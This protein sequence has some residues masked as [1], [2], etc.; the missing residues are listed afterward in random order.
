MKLDSHVAVITGASS[1]IGRAIALALA[2]QGV[3]VYLIGR[4]EKKLFAIADSIKGGQKV[5]TCQADLTQ[6]QDVRRVCEDIK[7]QFNKVDILIHSI[8]TIALGSMDAAPLT[9]FDLQLAVNVK[10]PY[11]LTKG[12]L[13]LIISSQGQIVFMNSSSGARSA[14]AQLGQYAATKHALK[15]IADSLREEVNSD[16]VRVLSVY[17][18]RT[19]TSMQE[20]IYRMEERDYHPERLLQPDDIASM[21]IAA[22]SLPG[23]AEVTDIHIRPMVKNG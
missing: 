6:D 10:V 20:A 1:G 4:S 18:G 16:G 12:L 2:A 21:V 15:A 9:D 7:R 5:I 22:L 8:G 13:P 17:P 14:Q 11:M 19:A 23:T 3:S